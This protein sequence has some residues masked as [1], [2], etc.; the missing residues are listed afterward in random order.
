MWTATPWGAVH[1]LVAGVPDKGDVVVVPGLGVSV[2]LR[3]S[4]CSLGAAGFRAWLADPPG[5]GD[6]GDPPHPLDIGEIAA[7]FAHWLRDRDLEQ[8]TLI[9]H[10]CGTQIAARVAA[11]E[12]DLVQRLV[13]GSPTVDPRYRSWP[14]AL[15]RWVRDGR[16]EPKSLTRTQQPEWRRAG[17]ARLFRLTRSMLADDLET[18]LSHVTCPVVVARAEHDPISTPEWAQRLAQGEDRNLVKIPGLAHAFP[19]QAPGAFADV[20]SGTE[21]S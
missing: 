5:F 13:L 6:S 10:S 18:S 9:G 2:Y 14:K 11:A 12:P 20:L 3:Q 17:A 15:L 19:Y 4:V 1:A 16:L 7:V 21:P 8:V